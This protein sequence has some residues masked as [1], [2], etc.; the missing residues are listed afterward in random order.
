MHI[1]VI[2]DNSD[3]AANLGDYLADRG[4]VVDFAADGI[5][6]LHMAMSEPFDVIILDLTLPG[7]DGLQVCK[8]LR[9]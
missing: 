1:L 7:M 4:H 9:A 6:G 3:L 2:E 8:R 5:R